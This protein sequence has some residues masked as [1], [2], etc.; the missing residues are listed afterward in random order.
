MLNII[1]SSIND[2]FIV[3]VYYLFEFFKNDVFISI[4]EDVCYLIIYIINQKIYSRFFKQFLIVIFK[5]NCCRNKN[6]E[7]NNIRYSAI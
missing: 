7:S 3:I 5:F 4:F 2:E 6:R 1:V